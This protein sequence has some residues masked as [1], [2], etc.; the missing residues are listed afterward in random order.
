MSAHKKKKSEDGV[1]TAGAAAPVAAVP[2]V[3]KK[4]ALARNDEDEDFP[5]GGSVGLTPLEY[6]EV[7]RE[8]ERD[9]LFE[10]A[11][12]G[13]VVPAGPVAGATT[14][15]KAAKKDA[16]AGEPQAKK[17]KLDSNA[18]VSQLRFKVRTTLPCE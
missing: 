16:A 6:R 4:A 13:G 17:T 15:K 3:A 5:R 11:Q 14:T 8:A 10:M 12:S 1:A 18:F 9:V 2:V 7:Q